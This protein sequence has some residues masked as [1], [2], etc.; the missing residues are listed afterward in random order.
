MLTRAIYISDAVG[1]AGATA[2]SMAEIFGAA[3]RNNRRDHL[4]G[5]LLYHHGGFLH[6]IE[7]ARADVD[8]LLRRLGED[9]R[10][11]RL[12]LLANGPVDTRLFDGQPLAQCRVTAEVDR[13][14][15]PAGLSLLTAREAERLLTAAAVPLEAAG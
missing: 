12:T 8:R 15:G 7:G 13:L 9:R 3:L 5:A 14:I 11:E 4:T 1:R 2:L 6:L 10:H